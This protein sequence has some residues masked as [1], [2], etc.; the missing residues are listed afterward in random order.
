MVSLTSKEHRRRNLQT[1]AA[2]WERADG[3]LADLAD[4]LGLS[5]SYLSQL[6][7]GVR[8]IGDATARKIEKALGWPRASLDHAIGPVGTMGNKDGETPPHW[9]SQDQLD[10]RL[11][12]ILVF[13][14]AHVAPAGAGPAEAGDRQQSVPAVSRDEPPPGYVRFPL[15]EDVVLEAGFEGYV[16]DVPETVTYLDV[17]ETWAQRN[18]GSP[19]RLA[20]LRLATVRG[21]SMSPKIND[22]DVIFVDPQVQHFVGPG[23]Y[24]L[25]IDGR[26]VV[27]ILDVDLVS[28]GVTVRSVNAADFPDQQLPKGHSLHV[29]GIVVG[30]WTFQRA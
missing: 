10:R 3:K 29:S 22:G 15:L 7:S 24:C 18:L 19:Q 26:P 6:R 30:W 8:G 25:N 5:P 1:L 11:A 28:G 16:A 14:G 13:P 17:A 9:P 2:E 12:N 21:N 4:H 20:R 27:K 23:I